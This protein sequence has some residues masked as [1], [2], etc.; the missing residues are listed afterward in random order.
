MC[1]RNYYKTHKDKK[2]LYYI[3]VKFVKLLIKKTIA[4]SPSEKNIFLN[5]Y[6]DKK[7]TKKTDEMIKKFSEDYENDVEDDIED[8]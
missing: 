6:Q 3:S 1:L 7:L 5:N 4:I 2:E 8:E